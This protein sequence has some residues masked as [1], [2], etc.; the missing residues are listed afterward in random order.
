MSI[1]S[2]YYRTM[3]RLKGS[4]LNKLG[5]SLV[6]FTATILIINAIGLFQLSKQVLGQ[7]FNEQLAEKLKAQENFGMREMRQISSFT[8]NAFKVFTEAKEGLSAGDYTGVEKVSEYI[9]QLNDINGYVIADASGE[10]IKSTYEGWEPTQW[11]SVKNFVTFMSQNGHK[12]YD[13]YLDMLNQGFCIISAHAIEDE[14]G[15]VGAYLI[16]CLDRLE[17]EYY[18]KETGDMLGLT[19]SVFRGREG[20]ASSVQAGTEDA[21]KHFALFDEAI[22]DTV[23]VK[24]NTYFAYANYGDYTF[25]SCYVPIIDYRGMRVGMYNAAV[26]VTVM[27]QIISYIVFALTIVDFFIGLIVV[28]FVI[29][30][31]RKSLAK[32]IENITASV[33]RISSGDMTEK[34]VVFKSGDEVERLSRGVKYMHKSL[35]NT[36]GNMIHTA[37]V[38]HSS[39]EE[40]SKAANKLS[41]GA[42]KQAASLEEISSSLE[43]MT[44]NIHQ[45]TENAVVTDKMMSKAD[46]AVQAIGDT[47]TD[48]MVDSQKIAGSIRDI[49]QLVNQTNILSLNASVEAARAG[50]LGRGFAV[51]AKEVGRLAEQTKTTAQG[52]SDTATK[53][54]AG[55]EN[56]NTLIDEVLPQLHQV[57]SMLKEIATS[58]QE[59]GIGADQINTAIS[60]LNSVTQETAANAEEIAANAVELSRT[61][62]KLKNAVDMFK[63]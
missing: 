12:A 19:A 51:V 40:L 34:V 1:S 20:V 63:L 43:E 37:K 58:S 46:K 48:N 39:S 18:L 35:G 29:R 36:I 21:G 62:D 15:E 57:A 6:L 2:V 17:D 54:I 30:Y 33:E 11:Q 26:N 7:H 45:N 41:D 59:Q 56:I 28:F 25:L 55:A 42:N 5:L 53:T 14:S 52:V 44:G 9:R 49:N 22:G 3:D 4:I 61:A 13:G 10:M 31:F 16:V 24:G 8:D 38:L 47:A 50:A 32:P 23:L 60:G 27:R